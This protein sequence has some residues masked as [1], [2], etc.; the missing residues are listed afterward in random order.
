MKSKLTGKHYVGSTDDLK[1][2]LGEHN[3]GKVI[4]TKSGLPWVLVYYEA[5]SVRV[6]AR[7]AELFY[8]TGQGRRQLKKKLQLEDD[9]IIDL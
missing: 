6:L 5:Y 1:N 9:N 2:R 3:H 4:S 8:K 7:K